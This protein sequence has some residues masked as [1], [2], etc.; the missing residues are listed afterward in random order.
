[1]EKTLVDKTASKYENVY[2]MMYYSKR[3]P[4]VQSQNAPDT[5]GFRAEDT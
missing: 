5:C 4:R 2:N 1:M 3:L